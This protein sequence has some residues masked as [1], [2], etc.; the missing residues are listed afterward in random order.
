MRSPK[1]PLKTL[2]YKA[3]LSSALGSF[4]YTSSGG[5]IPSLDI[6][7]RLIYAKAD[8]ALLTL[9]HGFAQRNFATGLKQ[10]WS[11]SGLPNR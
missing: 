5:M 10:H 4:F 1:K 11:C 3:T 8:I 2:R 6:A 9:Q 7:D